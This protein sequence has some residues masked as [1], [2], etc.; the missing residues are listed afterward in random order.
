MIKGAELI[1]METF[2]KV[3]TMATIR[4][5]R[6][7]TPMSGNIVELGDQLY[8]ITGVVFSANTS[9][10]RERLDNNIFDCQITLVVT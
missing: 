4:F 2:T 5:P 3:G 1:S 6:G 7:V 10:R 9:I 8:K